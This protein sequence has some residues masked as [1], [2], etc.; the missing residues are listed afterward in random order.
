MNAHPSFSRSF[1]FT[2]VEL[3]TVIAIIAILMGLL[4][5][6]ISIVKEQA[7][8]AEARTTCLGVVTAVKAYH[9]EYGK[10]PTGDEVA[11]GDLKIGGTTGDNAKLFFI[12]RAK[13]A[14]G[15]VGHKYN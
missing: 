4:F 6:V 2:L 12:L 9:T 3:L 13:D 5:P 15:N 1:A 14:A 10:Y 7:R 8:K 11:N